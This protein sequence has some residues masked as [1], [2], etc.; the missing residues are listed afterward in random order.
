GFDRVYGPCTELLC[1]TLTGFARSAEADEDRSELARLSGMDV[2]DLK[3]ARAEVGVAD[4]PAKNSPPSRSRHRG[5]ERSMCVPHT[6]GNPPPAVPRRTHL[7]RS[8]RSAQPV[9]ST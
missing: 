4:P 9:R 7:P 5:C 1:T 8:H 3:R 2:R 6:G